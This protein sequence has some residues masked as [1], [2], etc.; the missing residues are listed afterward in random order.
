MIDLISHIELLCA[1][2]TGLGA[3]LWVRQVPRHDGQQGQTLCVNA[4]P[5]RKLPLTAAACSSVPG[6]ALLLVALTWMSVLPGVQLFQQAS[7]QAGPLL[8]PD[9]KMYLAPQKRLDGLYL[10]ITMGVS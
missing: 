5:R 9:V 1:A 3:S 8:Q 2:D 6:V 7:H 10:Q 4:R